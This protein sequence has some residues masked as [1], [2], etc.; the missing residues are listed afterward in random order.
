MSVAASIELLHARLARVV[1]PSALREFDALLSSLHGDW[2]LEALL[3]AFSGTS[4]QLGRAALGADDVSLHG[5]LDAVPMTG[6]SADVAGRALLLLTVSEPALDEAVWAAYREGDTLEKLAVV[7]TLSLLPAATQPHFVQ[8]ALDAGRTND[9]RLFEAL[10]CDNP[11]PARHYE[12]LEWN[13]LFMK[14]AFVRAPLE[15]MLGLTR[16]ENPELARM[17]LEYVE[18]QESAGRAF[19]AAIWL[20]IAAF[21]PP[22]AVAKLLGYASHAV[23]NVRLGA[24]RGLLRA[25]DPRSASFLSERLAIEPDDAV[26]V[27]I[28]ETLRALSRTTDANANAG[29]TVIP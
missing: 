29:R 3:S 9:A 25:R 14:A 20:G 6:F 5:P 8:L 7:R 28:E 10:A 22:G 13:K 16:R 1:S 2:T 15:R 19:P 18:E 27:A 24:V 17:A 11:F 21:P 26:R 4:R 23:A 12:E